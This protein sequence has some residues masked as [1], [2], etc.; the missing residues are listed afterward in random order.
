MNHLKSASGAKLNSNLPASEVCVCVCV[1]V[2]SGWLLRHLRNRIQSVGV[3]VNGSSKS[4]QT[5]LFPLRT[6]SGGTLD[7]HALTY[8]IN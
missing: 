8:T 4:H 2:A 7:F 1:P 3:D 6:A 5:F